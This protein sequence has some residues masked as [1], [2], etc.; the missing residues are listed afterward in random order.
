MHSAIGEL[1][2]SAVTILE[3]SVLTTS[4]IEKLSEVVGAG[5]GLTGGI[6]R[7]CAPD[8][9]FPCHLVFGR[10]KLQV[11]CLCSEFFHCVTSLFASQA[12]TTRTCIVYTRVFVS[13]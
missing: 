13:Y 3:N 1:F 6:A 5:D 10:D 7:C 8:T 4:D 12:A 2:V 9:R 11:L